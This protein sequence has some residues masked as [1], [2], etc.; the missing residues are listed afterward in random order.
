V[1]EDSFYTLLLTIIKV[2]AT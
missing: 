1:S 2:L